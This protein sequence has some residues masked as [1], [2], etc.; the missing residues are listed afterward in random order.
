MEKNI[1]SEETV[2]ETNDISKETNINLETNKTNPKENIN[3][4]SD[5]NSNK[6][7]GDLFK[8]YV[9]NSKKDFNSRFSQFLTYVKAKKPDNKSVIIDNGYINRET[10]SNYDLL[11]TVKE[12]KEVEANSDYKTSIEK[13]TNLIYDLNN[14]L[15]SNIMSV[16]SLDENRLE[17]YL[18]Q[19]KN[20]GNLIILAD[21][22]FITSLE[23]FFKKQLTKNPNTNYLIKSV[24]A[25]KT[26]LISFVS[27]QKF[28]L[29]TPVNLDNVKIHLAETVQN[30]SSGDDLQINKINDLTFSELIRTYEHLFIINEMSSYLKRVSLYIKFI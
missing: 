24:I 5:L 22:K 2:N 1:I 28:V 3:K 26:P 16:S 11:S 19:L 9:N 4:N 14:F 7:I 12:A 13:D 30:F 25:Y 21:L 8:L 17:F 6:T 23:E 18:E 20:L 10:I 29:K 15:T 27:I